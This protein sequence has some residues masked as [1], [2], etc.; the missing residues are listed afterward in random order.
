MLFDAEVRRT[1][2]PY[3]LRCEFS[4]QGRPRC[5]APLLPGSAKGS[6]DDSLIPVI[7]VVKGGPCK[8][9]DRVKVVGSQTGL[10]AW[11]LRKAPDLKRLEGGTW[12]QQVMLPLGDAYFKV[13]HTQ[14]SNRDVP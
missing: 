5:A 8:T 11:D 1:L 4:E 14:A 10:G 13:S 7:V 2:R 9:A 3:D 6:L 12:L